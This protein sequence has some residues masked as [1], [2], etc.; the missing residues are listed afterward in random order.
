MSLKYALLGLLSKEPS[1]GYHLTQRFRETLIHFWNAH[2]TQIYRELAKMEAEELVHSELVLQDDHPDKKVYTI[3]EKGLKALLYWLTEEPPDIPKMKDEMLLRVS[4]F[5]LIP[6]KRAIEMLEASKLH[7]GIVLSRM[8]EWVQFRYEGNSPDPSQ[9]G[10]YL[11]SEYGMR[12]MKN[13]ISWCD[14][15]IELFQKMVQGE[16]N[17]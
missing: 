16:P 13:W 14:W 11:T 5:N 2:H 7:H 15:A 3:E 6:P 12:Y 4:L 9:I 10:E 1:T 17:E 8:E